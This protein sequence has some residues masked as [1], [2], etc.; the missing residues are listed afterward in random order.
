MRDEGGGMKIKEEEKIT[1]V[2]CSFS[3][4]IPHP[5]SL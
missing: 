5:S 1:R 4:L 3:S 2:G